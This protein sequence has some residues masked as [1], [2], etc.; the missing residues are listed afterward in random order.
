[1]KGGLDDLARLSLGARRE[2]VRYVQDEF[3][4]R[5]N[6]GTVGFTGDLSPGEEELKVAG[7]IEEEART[8]GPWY[9][10]SGKGRALARVY[11]AADPGVRLQT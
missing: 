5:R 9:V 10:L 3:E 11:A 6:G 4:S 2:F 8:L 7:L 1:M